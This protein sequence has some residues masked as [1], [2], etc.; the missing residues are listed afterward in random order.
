MTVNVTAGKTAKKKPTQNERILS[1]LTSG[2]TL[3]KEQAAVKYKIL[4][5]TSRIAELRGQGVAIDAKRARVR[6]RA[7]GE[8]RTVVRYGLAQTK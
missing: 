6:D 2:K 7:T 5:L 8:V 1:L 4:S 3:T